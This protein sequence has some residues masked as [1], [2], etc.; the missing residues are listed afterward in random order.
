MCCGICCVLSNYYSYLVRKKEYSLTWGPCVNCMSWP[1]VSF[2][3]PCCGL[4]GCEDATGDCPGDMLLDWGDD[5]ATALCAA[6]ACTDAEA[7]VDP[8]L[9]FPVG[10]KA[11]WDCPAKRSFLS[12]KLPWR[13]KT[14]TSFLK[15]TSWTADLET[16][17][18]SW[19]LLCSERK[20]KQASGS[21]SW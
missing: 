4:V 21:S 20:L 13:A 7:G 10:L 8:D 11:C 3:W 1:I 15:M 16:L 18:L 19:L 14:S 2:T 17:K 12:L 9:L 5:V 6:V